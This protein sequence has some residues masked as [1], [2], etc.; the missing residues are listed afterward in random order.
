MHFEMRENATGR[1]FFE[2]GKKRK[3]MLWCRSR[4]SRN[5]NNAAL[6]KK[7][8]L[9]RTSCSCE[10]SGLDFKTASCALRTRAAATNRIASV[11]LRVF[12][13]LLIRSLRTRVFPS[14]TTVD[15]RMEERV[16]VVTGEKAFTTPRTRAKTAISDAF[17][18]VIE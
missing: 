1:K 3:A 5:I 7:I 10:I 13:T 8:A 2:Y 12:L 17:I 15:P 16:D 9:L 14:M 11:I 6:C 4:H 18:F